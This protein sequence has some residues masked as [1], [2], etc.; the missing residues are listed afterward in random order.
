MNGGS[1]FVIVYRVD[2]QNGTVATYEI[3]AREAEPMERAQAPAVLAQFPAVTLFRPLMKMVHVVLNGSAEAN[4]ERTRGVF[5]APSL[6]PGQAY[7]IAVRA[8]VEVRLI[9]NNFQY[10][11]LHKLA[12]L[13]DKMRVVKT[14]T[15]KDAY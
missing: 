12:L 2:E 7:E 11:L 14:Q 10:L 6:M 15:K 3:L 5:Y 1:G 13:A 4:Q 9:C 8:C